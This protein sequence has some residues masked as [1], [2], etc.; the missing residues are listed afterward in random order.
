MSMKE[1]I[2]KISVHLTVSGF[3]TGLS[4]IIMTLLGGQTTSLDRLV[5]MGL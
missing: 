3:L 5:P 1:A 2:L 4:C